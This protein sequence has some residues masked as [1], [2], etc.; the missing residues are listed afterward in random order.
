[1]P[2]K[3][4]TRRGKS[5]N[6]EKTRTKRDIATGK[7]SGSCESVV[8][9]KGTDKRYVRRNSDGRFI[10]VANEH[11]LRAWDSIHKTSVRGRKAS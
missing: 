9:S 3:N 7:G 2:T 5:G 10:E 1:M 6:S 4:S 11:M 8:L